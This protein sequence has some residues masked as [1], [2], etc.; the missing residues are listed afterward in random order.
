MTTKIICFY[1]QNM[2]IQ[3]SQTGGQWYSD[4]PPFSIPCFHPLK[5]ISFIAGTLT[6]STWSCWT[7]WS[8]CYKTFT[9]SLSLSN[10]PNKLKCFV[11]DK[12]FQPEL[13]FVSKVR[14]CLSGASYRHSHLELAPVLTIKY[15]TGKIVLLGINILTYL[16]FSSVV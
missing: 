9:F 5:I 16:A 6:V 3:T 10:G 2:L 15:K 4:T 12:T 1:L 13:K 14:A 7:S 11:P 8:Q